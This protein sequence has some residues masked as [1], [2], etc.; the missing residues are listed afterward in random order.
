LGAGTLKETNEVLCCAAAQGMATQ[1]TRA[2]VPKT[3]VKSD[4]DEGSVDVDELNEHRPGTVSWLDPQRTAGA[5]NLVD[6]WRT[7]VYGG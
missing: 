1:L 5:K 3:A 7:K 2:L 6:L 4:G